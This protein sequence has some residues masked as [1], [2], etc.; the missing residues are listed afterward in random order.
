[1]DE[2]DRMDPMDGAQNWDCVAGPCDNRGRRTF[3]G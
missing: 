3:G 2:M 1:M